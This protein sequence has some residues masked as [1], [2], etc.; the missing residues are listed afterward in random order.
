MS[1]LVMM[2][3]TPPED[4]DLAIDFR[5]IYTPFLSEAIGVGVTQSVRGVSLLCVTQ[6]CVLFYGAARV[7]ELLQPEGGIQTF[8]HKEMTVCY[9]KSGIT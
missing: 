2:E 3:L 5:A 9:V 4:S 8:A 1:E 6:L 7:V